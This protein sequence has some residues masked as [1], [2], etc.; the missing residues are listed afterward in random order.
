[1]CEGAQPLKV[2]R[3]VFFS[4][5]VI[6]HV[7]HGEEIRN[8]MAELHKLR[9]QVKKLV[10]DRSRQAQQEQRVRQELLLQSERIQNL[11]HELKTIL[12]SSQKRFVEIYKR[13]KSHSGWNIINLKGSQEYF[14]KVQYLKSLN[15]FD[16]DLLEKL[17]THQRQLEIEKKQFENR[18]TQLKKIKFQVDES[19]FELQAKESEKRKLIQQLEQP[20]SDF[21][22][23]RGQ[24][25][26]PVEGKPYVHFGLRRE[27]RTKAWLLGSGAYFQSSV[28]IINSS[29]RG[30]VKFLGSLPHWG[31]TLILEHGES[32]FTVYTNVKNPSVGLG[33]EVDVGQKL[34][35]LGDLKYDGKYDHYFEIRQYTEPQN[36]KEWLKMGAVK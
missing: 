25:I 13:K 31:P 32:F 19:L 6:S 22:L 3:I 17:R 12:N 16:T 20:E 18:L 11:S 10:F 33:D 27:P 2:L 36:P 29:A 15:K 21:S 5:L 1:M 4:L 35:D 7:S 8:K 23:L 9:E 26:P 30:T 34:A 28:R 14:R 24:L